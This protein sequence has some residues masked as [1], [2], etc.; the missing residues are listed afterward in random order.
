[1]TR[2]IKQ[3]LIG[4]GILFGL[5]LLLFIGVLSYLKTD[6][7][8]RLIQDRVNDLIPGAV[9]CEGFHFSLLKGNFEL[10][11]MLLKDPSGNDMAG[12]DRFLV[13]LTWSTLFKGELTVESLIIEKPWAT[14]RVDKKNK[15]NLMRAFP[16]SKATEQKTKKEKGMGVPFNIVFKSLK[17]VQGSVHFESVAEDLNIS[18]NNIDLTAD[19]NFLKQSGNLMFCIGKGHLKSPEIQT[20]FDRFKL[21][22][23]LK[24]GRIDPLV[25]CA[26]ATSS[27]I[28][29]SGNIGD[30]FNKPILDLTLDLSTSL[31]EMQKAFCLKPMSTGRVEMQLN[32]R[33]A[34]DNPRGTWRLSYGGGIISGQ[35]VDRIDLDCRLEDRLLIVNKLQAHAASGDINIQGEIDLRDA[36]ANGFLD[37]QRDLK[38]ISYNAFLKQKEIRLEELLPG[39]NPVAGIVQSSL[40]VCGKGISPQTLSAK[41]GMELFVTNFTAGPSAAPIDVR[42]KSEAS[43]NQGIA[44]IKDLVAGT[45]DIKFQ[46]NGHIDLS[47]EKLSATLALDAPTITGILS[48]FG[49]QKACGKLGLKGNVSG[50]IKQPVL[51]FVL[52]GDELCFREITIE[53]VRLNAGLDKAGILRVSQIAIDNRGSAFHGSGWI[54][55]F[56]KDFSASILFDETDLSPYFKIA[57][58]PDIK[59]VLTGKIKAG[60]NLEAMDHVKASVG[61]SK[62][63]LFF[64]DKEIAHARNLK[65]FLDQ[66]KITIPLSHLFLFK[67][68]EIDIKGTGTLNGPLALQ[69]EGR[70]PLEAAG[71]FVED[72]SD[73]EGDLALSATVGG[74]QAHPDIQAEIGLEKIAFTV[75]T[76]LRRVHDINGRI[77]LNAHTITVDQIKGRLD[78]GRFDLAGKIDLE[79]FQPAKVIMNVNANAIPLQ[80]PDTADILLNTELKIYGT[81]DKSTIQGEVVILEGTYY[82]DVDLNLIHAVQTKEREV[83]VLPTKFTQ[84]FLKNTTM[85]ISVKHRLPFIVDNNLA[86]LE[87]APDLHITGDL[88]NPVISGQ[89]EIESGKIEYKQKTFVIK[90]GTINFVNPYKTEPILDI[91]SETQIRDWLIYLNISGAL[92]QLVFKL[93]SDPLETD[94]DILSLLVFGKTT[95]ELI[96]GGDGASQT[97][98]Q[99]LSELIFSTFGEDI[100][101]V[102]GLDI[103][104]VETKT[105]S[106][107]KS[108]GN[109]KITVGENLSRRITVKYATEM[110]DGE[111]SQ[112]AIAEYKF[113]E[114]ILISG[115]QDSKGTFGGDLRFRLEFR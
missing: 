92:D 43:L 54:H 115:F 64:K 29:L 93:T 65:I 40:S 70:I 26:G 31:A 30:V 86:L 113:L 16:A 28:M 59:G 96:E 10:G 75:P 68:G 5:I 46:T 100:Q 98:T 111:I 13:D 62:V 14:I 74:T 81:R 21:K 8:G 33:G 47:S 18:A 89:A 3:I 90:R 25:L 1:M 101:D 105:Q 37:P 24:H 58:Q 45:G 38:A 42:L 106:E 69:M 112:R 49:I 32:V 44:T 41:I 51:D 7:A 110:E 36:F 104:E 15:I 108:V 83:A 103:L 73:A 71:L 48:S 63:V 88:N 91:K 66:D 19:G 52:K 67:K 55:V 34:L 23:T 114:N 84:P 72:F 12:C 97:T 2:R 50:S 27:E 77:H 60:G 4:T 9:L 94:G 56:K 85:D 79:A 109:I 20:E 53:K 87:I 102:T 99:M 6:H 17:L 76:I 95:H 11:R 82:R 35:R 22:T 78:D 80:V 61:F 107:E 39:V 57:N